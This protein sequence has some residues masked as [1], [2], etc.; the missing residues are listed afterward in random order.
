[1]VIA[2]EKM[3]KAIVPKSEKVYNFAQALDL[4]MKEVSE[5][6]IYVRDERTS[7]GL[8]QLYIILTKTLLSIVTLKFIILINLS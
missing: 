3:K 4:N 2:G 5:L 1:M 7:Q 6:H 8:R